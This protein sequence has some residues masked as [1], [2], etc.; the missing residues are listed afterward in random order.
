MSKEIIFRGI[1]V[2]NKSFELF[3]LLIFLSVITAFA[4]NYIFLSDEL[5]SLS[6]EG[7]LASDR[8]N[9]MIELSHKW[10]WVGYVL[11][12]VMILIR[13][14]YTAACLY[15][16]CF[17]AEIRVHFGKL[18]KIALLADFV[19]VV[20]GIM[21]LVFLIFFKDISTLDDLQF[22]PL[23]IMELFDRSA[24]E[25]CF[26]YPL[27]VINLFELLYWLVLTG[28]LSEVIEKPFIK[29]LK[30]V[31]FSYGSGLLLWVLV[32]MFLTLNLLQ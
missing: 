16:G 25:P 6:F 31:I 13:V 4:F 29:S 5:L 7:I 22:Q 26:I 14:G 1:N 23:S 27:S 2:K 11:I 8:I 30:T 24:I 20:A 3:L 15:M 28:L 19:F 18:F 12:P 10:Q 21:K 32:G 9:G 17:I